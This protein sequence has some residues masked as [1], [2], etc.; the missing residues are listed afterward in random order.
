MFLFSE[1]EVSIPSPGGG[2]RGES[3][4]L[5]IEG[6]KHPRAVLSGSKPFR[7][8][9]CVQVGRKSREWIHDSRNAKGC[10]QQASA[11]AAL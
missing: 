7:D 10:G 6:V 4:L 3:L 1:F 8:A 5:W 9:P 11:R 2:N